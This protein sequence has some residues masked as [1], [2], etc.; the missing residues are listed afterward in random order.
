MNHT[1]LQIFKTVAEEQSVTRA[2]K[3]LGRAQSNITTRIHQL[4]EELGVELFARGNKKM[5]LSPAGENFL[6]Y[7]VKILSLAEEAKQALH[8]ATPGGNLRLG[9]MDA[10][11]ASRLPQILP[12]FH[13]QCPE[14][15]LTLKTQPTRQLIQ[16]VLDASLDC[17]LV[18]LPQ[19][20]IPPDD[21]EYQPV[22]KEQLVMM[23]PADQQRFRF[24]AFPDGCTYR[25]TGEAFLA[26]SEE[27]DIK[28]QDIGSYHAMLACVATG[29][30]ACLL[31]QSVLDTLKLPEGS[32]VRPIGEALTQLIWR[33]G[34]SS[35]A[36][37]YLR[38]LLLSAS[39]L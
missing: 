22:F 23:L 6:G 14:V 39:N 26:Q 16:Q 35:P 2:A 24:A 18:S 17:A 1:T 20:T 36:L 15:I 5:L 11:A 30:Y 8:P 25:A 19:G 31:P 9:S 34:Y 27:A 13:A 7:A 32:L 12:R 38:Q 4:E 37:N 33:K 29:G 28:I 3:L 10:T 21:L